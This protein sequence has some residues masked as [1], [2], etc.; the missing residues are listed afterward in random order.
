MLPLS[1]GV[2]LMRILKLNLYVTL[3]SVLE[4]TQEYEFAFYDVITEPSL[5]DKIN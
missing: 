4:L 1:P 5:T 2:E 3:E